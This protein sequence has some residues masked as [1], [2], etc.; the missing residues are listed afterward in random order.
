MNAY[1]EFGWSI[2]VFDPETKEFLFQ[3]TPAGDDPNFKIQFFGRHQCINEN[4]T[5]SIETI[6]S[7]SNDTIKGE[8]RFMTHGSDSFTVTCIMKKKTEKFGVNAELMFNEIWIKGKSLFKG[9]EIAKQLSLDIIDEIDQKVNKGMP[10]AGIRNQRKL[11]FHIDGHLPDLRR[12]E[13][14]M[15]RD[16]LE[17]E[18]IKMI[19]RKKTDWD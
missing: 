16:D 13:D 6:C 17:E 1:C 11:E 3:Y 14:E 2:R 12:Q 9:I 19:K 7:L 8:A 4:L 15:D 5:F 18:L 10:L